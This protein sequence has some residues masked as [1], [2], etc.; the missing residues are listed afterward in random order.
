MRSRWSQTW[1][2]GP[3]GGYY[4]PTDPI[5]AKA[6]V[7]RLPNVHRTKWLCLDCLK[8]RKDFHE[9][10][11]FDRR[12]CPSCG[13]LAVRVGATFRPPKLTEF[14]AWKRALDG[15]KWSRLT[16]EEI[17]RARATLEAKRG[18]K[19]RKS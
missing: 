18:R 2:P 16:P 13:G 1:V 14:R 8:T 3:Y 7:K 4:L 19:K 5:K 17:A 12:R 6:S 9:G 10:P 15:L 11:E